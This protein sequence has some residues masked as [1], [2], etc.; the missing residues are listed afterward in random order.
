MCQRERQTAY[1]Q[2]VIWLWLRCR[3]Q[4]VCPTLGS[5]LVLYILSRST[6][7]ASMWSGCFWAVI[8]LHAEF[9]DTGL[10]KNN[11]LMQFTHQLLQQ[12]QSLLFKREHKGNSEWCQGKGIILC[13]A[14][15]IKHPDWLSGRVCMNGNT[16]LELRLRMTSA[17]QSPNIYI[18]DSLAEFHNKYYQGRNRQNL[19]IERKP[20]SFSGHPPTFLRPAEDGFQK[21]TLVW[22]GDPMFTRRWA[23]RRR[24]EVTVWKKRP[25]RFNDITNQNKQCVLSS[26]ACRSAGVVIG[27]LSFPDMIPRMLLPMFCL[28]ADDFCSQRR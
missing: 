20:P 27:H 18:R 11:K 8:L 28:W 5:G 3:W 24:E 12:N 6:I 7:M 23:A 13:R 17:T 14:N 15:V 4:G 16:I 19:C 10:H 25:N 22:T 1:L 2:G 26:Q 9:P 21:I